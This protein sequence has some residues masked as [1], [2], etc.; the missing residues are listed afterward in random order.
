MELLPQMDAPPVLSRL[1]FRCIEPR[2]F[3][4]ANGSVVTVHAFGWM[5]ADKTLPATESEARCLRL[6][7]VYYPDNA[8]E[9]LDEHDVAFLVGHDAW[10]S[11]S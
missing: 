1:G 10:K 5:L 4:V 2:Q 6:Y 11:S 3:K 7:T 8:T 9:E